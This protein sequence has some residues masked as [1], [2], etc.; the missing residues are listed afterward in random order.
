LSMSITAFFCCFINLIILANLPQAM[1][2]ITIKDFGTISNNKTRR[3][4]FFVSGLIAHWSLQS[5]NLRYL[6][7]SHSFNR[8]QKINGET[9]HLNDAWQATDGLF[10]LKRNRRYPEECGKTE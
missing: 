4:F 10:N 2:Y 5:M 6:F 1:S 9:F 8:T 7:S 3:F